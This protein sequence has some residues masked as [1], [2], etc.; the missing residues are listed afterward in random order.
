MINPVI[1]SGWSPKNKT[2]S[3]NIR[4]G[5]KIQVTRKEAINNFGFLKICIICEKSIFVSGG[6]I[7]KINPIAKGILVV[8]EENELI[9][10]AEFGMK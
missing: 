10:L 6:Y 3:K 8:P 1:Y 4:N 5:P 2:E 9:K 7:I